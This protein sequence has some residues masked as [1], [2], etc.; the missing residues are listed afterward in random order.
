[1]GHLQIRGIQYTMDT[2]KYRVFNTHG[3]FT[4][5]GDSIHMGHFQKKGIQYKWDIYKYRVF[6]THGTLIKMKDIQY[7]WDT[8]KS[9]GLFITMD[10]GKNAGLF[11]T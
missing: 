2:Y 5:T 10:S 6:N 4:N 9:A 3:K 7:K 1:M 8:N 11:N